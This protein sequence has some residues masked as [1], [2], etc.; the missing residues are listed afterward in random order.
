MKLITLF[1]IITISLSISVVTESDVEEL[2]MEKY[3]ECSELEFSD[4]C[5]LNIWKITLRPGGD[6]ECETGQNYPCIPCQEEL[7]EDEG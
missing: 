5:D 1:L 2:N 7:E 4:S 3:T 6:W